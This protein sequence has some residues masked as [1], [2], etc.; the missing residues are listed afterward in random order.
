TDAGLHH[1]MLI[2]HIPTRALQPGLAQLTDP[3]PPRAQHPAH[4]RAQL[5][6]RSGPAHPG[7]RIRS[8]TFK[9]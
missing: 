2:S 8:M 1:A 6:A 5:P 4:R 9:T 3:D 7:G